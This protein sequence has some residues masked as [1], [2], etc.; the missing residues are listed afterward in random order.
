MYIQGTPSFLVSSAL[1][2]PCPSAKY[3]QDNQHI[4]QRGLVKWLEEEHKVQVTQATVSM[5]LT[6][7]AELLDGCTE[8]KNVNQ[9]TRR[10]VMYPDMEKALVEWIQEYQL[11]VNVSRDMI[12]QKG[13]KMLKRLHPSAPPFNFSPGWLDK[14]KTRHQIQSRRRFGESGSVNM[15][16]CVDALSAIRKVL[17]EYSLEDIYNMD[18]TR[19]FYRMQADNSLATK[20]L[21]GRKQ[22]KERITIVICCNADGNDK[23]PLCIIGKSLKPRCF[24]HLNMEALGCRYH[25]NKNAWMTQGVFRLWLLAFDRRMEGRNVILLMD[26]CSAHIRKEDL[27]NHNIHLK[28]TQLFYLPPNTTS[29]LQPCDAGIIRTFKAYYRRRFNNILLQRLEANVDNPE[30]ISNLE[31]MQIAMAAWKEDVK[32][33]MIQNCFRHCKLRT[34][35]AGQETTLEELEP[36]ADVIAELEQQIAR[37]PYT[38]PMDIRNL[39]NYPNEDGAAEIP[40]DDNITENILRQFL[41]A[42]QEDVDDD[43]SEEQPVITT[44]QATAALAQL[45]LFW[46]Q[47]TNNQPEYCDILQK[48][49]DSLSQISEQKLRQTT[50]RSFFSRS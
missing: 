11:V 35:D 24:K 48:M 32:P 46:M 1:S 13:K 29:K 6:R 3:K 31:G 22:N 5:T 49:K 43:D 23:L 8:M 15:V 39:L 36:P 18:E 30:K 7:S 27:E 34:E 4:T 10:P 20:Q 38:N 17:D 9:K 2:S 28:N 41:P 14:F 21:E 33:T 19:L 37:L 44:R 25:A 40:T 45:E 26:N 50:I 47:Q 12:C 16:V 42:T